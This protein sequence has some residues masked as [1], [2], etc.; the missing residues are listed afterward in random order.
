VERFFERTTNANHNAAEI[1]ANKSNRMTC[2]HGSETVERRKLE[3]PSSNARYALR[4]FGLDEVPLECVSIEEPQR[5]ARH[6][7]HA[8]LPSHASV[9]RDVHGRTH[10]TTQ[11][12]GSTTR[13][14][15]FR[16]DD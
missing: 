11:R 12:I 2:N 3:R 10:A 9:P 6:R 1:N 7:L 8:S 13:H 14:R 16:S 15:A 5:R 4:R